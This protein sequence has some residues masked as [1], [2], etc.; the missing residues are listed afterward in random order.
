MQVSMWTKVVTASL[1]LSL[2]GVMIGSGPTSIGQEKEKEP[3]KTRKAERAKRRLP[4]F[5]GDVVTEEQRKKIYE[6]Q[7]KYEKQLA[8]LNE[9]LLALTKKQQEEIEALLSAEQ[10]SR[11][12]EARGAAATKRKKKADESEAKASDE[13]PAEEKPAEEKPADEKPAK[14][15]TGT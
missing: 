7:E 6:I 2:A 11:I 8:D 15:K 4:N 9:Q 1:I 10:K 5:Y 14:K 3:A 13:K 12:E